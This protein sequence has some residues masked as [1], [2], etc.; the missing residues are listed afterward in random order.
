MGSASTAATTAPSD[1]IDA[2]VYGYHRD[3]FSI[4]GPHVVE[5][6]LAI[7]TFQPGAATVAVVREGAKPVEM[8][9]VR[10]EGF[11]EAV[12]PRLKKVVPYQLI[13]T[14]HDGHTV[15]FEDPYRF[16][17]TL[18]DFD[19]HLLAEGTHLHIYQRLGA[20][21]TVLEGVS[22]VTFGVWAPAAQRVSVVGDFNNWDGRRHPMRFHPTN[23]IWELF[24]PGLRPG[25]IYKYEIKTSYMDYMVTKA[26]PVGFLSEMRPKN[27][28]V[29][30]DIN[31]YQWK[32]AGWLATRAERQRPE[33]PISIYELH[34]GSWRTKNNWKWLTYREL[35]EQLIPYVKELG[36]THIEL[37]PVAEHPFDGSWGYQVTGFFAPTSRFGTPDDFMAFVDAC[38]EAG[39]GVIVDWVPA[40]F[41]MDEHGLGFFDGT[42]LYEHADPRQGRHPDW[43]TYIFNYGRNEVSQF[44]ISNAVFWLDK[45]H[46]DGLRVDAVASMLYLDFSRRQGEWVANRY[47]GRENLEA[48]SFIRRFNEAVHR[49]YPDAITVAEESTSWPGVTR[50][51]SEGGL[52]F[53]YKWNMGWMHDTL[54]YFRDDPIYRSHHHGRLTFSL[55]YAFSEKFLLPFSHDEVVHLK[56][57]M[58]DKMPG[59]LWQRFANLR[60]LYAYQWSHPGKK[61]LFMGS[62]FGQWREWNEAVSLDWSLLDGDSRHRG[63]QKTVGRLNALLHSEPALHEEDYSWQGFEWLDLHDYERS[64]LA[65][66]RKSPGTGQN[67]YV[68]LNF[69]PVVRQG[70]RLGVLEEGSYVEIFNSDADDL[71][72]SNVRNDQPMPSQ[73]A[74]AHGKSLSIELT[75][76]PLAAVFIKRADS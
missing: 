21:V 59:D 9:R 58:L 24:I 23:G 34:L 36:F 62:E 39:I 51:V 14:Y 50:P 1:A 20:Q 70:Y 6:G 42:H 74:P 53:D 10:E 32:D 46:I 37:L 16:P 27:A 64:I 52:G 72:G 75:L 29:V 65:Y 12:L 73:P 55:L 30:W 47:G 54:Q 26:D 76:P 66:I 38:H 67:V 63:I 69:T 15:T 43:G 5:K 40:H 56:R 4:L 19:A 35:A 2:I 3:P 60:L 41:P 31:Q 49:L 25:D 48:I 7:R 68:V 13:V 17:P 11:Y 44:L 61:L 22:G 28:S 8:S 45:Y 57:S 71:G 18:S 33:A